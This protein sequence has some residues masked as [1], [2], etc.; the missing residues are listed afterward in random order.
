MYKK[1][2]EGITLLETM[3]S[4]GI[5]S[6]L[7]LL[8]FPILKTMYSTEILFTE[9]IKGSRNASRIIEIIEKDIKESSFG[10]G[11][12]I[13]KNYL[14]NGKVVIEHTGYI[15]NILK[16]EFFQGKNQKGNL[17]FLEIPFVKNETV[18]SKYII[19]RFYTGSLQLIECSL[20]S[21]GIFTERVEN[22][23]EE[24]DGYFEKDENGI[25]ITIE[26]RNKKG[27]T[28]KVFKGY[29]LMGKKYE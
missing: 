15:S 29:E 2:I 28:K 24:V 14:V 18:L 3:V 10:H 8:S 12:Y 9:E 17:L 1:K 21:G 25:K 5:M 13:G 23:L 22:I 11:E 20:F 4:I 6:I 16:E 7:L 26:I 27:K 19:Y